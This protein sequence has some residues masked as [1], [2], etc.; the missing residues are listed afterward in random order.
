MTDIRRTYRRVLLIWV[1]V[2]IALFAFQ[3]YFS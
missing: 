1:A 3:Q 2:L